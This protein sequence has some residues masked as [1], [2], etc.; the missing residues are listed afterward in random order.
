MSLLHITTLLITLSALLGWINKAFIGLP[1]AI[2]LLIM[3]LTGS[4][5]MIVASH[6]IPG[7]EFTGH[8][9]DAIRSI[10]FYETLMIGMLSFLLF[11]AALHVDV[12]KLRAY[13]TP[14]FLLASVGVVISMAIVGV[15]IWSLG[16]FLGVA[17]PLAWALTF[18][19]LIS[20][21]DPVAVLSILKTTRIPKGLEAKISGESLFNDGS[22]VIAFTVMLAVAMSASG[23]MTG[24]DGHT[25]LKASGEVDALLV[26]KVFMWEVFGG[27]LLGLVGGF[28]TFFMIKTIDD[29]A[30]ET[31]LSLALVLGT[32]VIA[33]KLHLS[34]PIAVVVAG[35]VIGNWGVNLAMSSRTKEHLLP[36]WNVLDDILNSVL[37][38]LI[39]LEISIMEFD[40]A[41]WS[42][43]LIAIPVVLFARLVSVA[44]PV[45]ALRLIGH[46]FNKGSVRIMTWGGVRGG[47][48]IALAL[49]IP[50]NEY[51]SLILSIT[52]VVVCFSI[53]VQGLTIKPLVEKLTYPKQAS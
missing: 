23:L 50:E 8:L 31:L 35:L 22:G 53:I 17:I 10:D 36:F 43:M 51:K 9:Q 3:G 41:H 18:G 7:F 48:S 32:T 52:Y 40:P 1:H 26:A 14:I 29:A 20:P 2:A 19:A 38:L 46:E 21:T 5:L 15:S 11:P 44:L 6:L 13:L 30:V 33:L 24:E 27:I 28:I 45:N 47:I 4:I 37:F 25:V 12:R 42:A 34:A 16:P 49:S 39:G